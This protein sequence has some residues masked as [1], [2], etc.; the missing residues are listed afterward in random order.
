M[1]KITRSQAEQIVN[2]YREVRDIS[3][4]HPDVSVSKPIRGGVSCVV[5]YWNTIYIYVSVTDMC[6]RINDVA[7]CD[8]DCDNVLVIEGTRGYARFDIDLDIDE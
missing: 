4:Q 6:V 3:A 7:R 5:E 1:A 8:I 2:A